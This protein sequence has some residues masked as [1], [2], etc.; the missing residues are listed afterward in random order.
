[1]QEASTV[2]LSCHGDRPCRSRYLY[3]ITIC[4]VDFVL[5]G[6]LWREDAGADWS[7]SCGLPGWLVDKSRKLSSRFQRKMTVY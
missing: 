6:G 1:M 4:N 5:S 7:S 2:D 3:S